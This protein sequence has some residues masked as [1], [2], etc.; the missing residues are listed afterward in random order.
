MYGDTMRPHKSRVP[1]VD[2]NDVVC[3]GRLVPYGPSP[4]L[5]KQ[6]CKRT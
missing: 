5:V 4:V 6:V 2:K 1:L 3:W